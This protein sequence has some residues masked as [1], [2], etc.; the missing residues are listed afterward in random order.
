MTLPAETGDHERL[1]EQ[2]AE[3]FR[4]VNRL[5]RAGPADEWASLNLTMAQVKALFILAAHE[6][7]R[8][9]QLAQCLS[10]SLPSA[11]GT[12]DR[13]VQAGLVERLADPDDRRLVL[14]RLTEAGRTLVEQLREG[15]RARLMA[16]L[17]RLSPPDLAALAQGLRALAVALAELEN[18]EPRGEALAA[19]SE[20]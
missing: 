18:G 4:R 20:R 7:C 16:G 9:G 3:D 15:R 14:V 12:V 13:L 19:E 17:Q 8:M 5:V 6:P 10:V 1:R 11:T 2:V